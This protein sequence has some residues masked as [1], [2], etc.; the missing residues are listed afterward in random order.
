MRWR[1]NPF[2]FLGVTY[3]QCL[4]GYWHDSAGMKE[5]I[6]KKEIFRW[7]GV[8]GG[9]V[10]T[11]FWSYVHQHKT[12]NKSLLLRRHVHAQVKCIYIMYKS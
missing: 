9:G 10:M 2:I 7:D 12:S 3:G 4:E 11:Q 5:G 8:G 6:K 1:A